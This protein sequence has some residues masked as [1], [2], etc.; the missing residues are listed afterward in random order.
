MPECGQK[1]K[2]KQKTHGLTF[3]IIRIQVDFVVLISLTI[4]KIVIAE[5]LGLKMKNSI[6]AKAIPTIFEIGPPQTK[7]SSRDCDNDTGNKLLFTIADPALQRE[8]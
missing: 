4:A 3:I 7:T 2:K 5:S 6:K 8:Q 1:Q